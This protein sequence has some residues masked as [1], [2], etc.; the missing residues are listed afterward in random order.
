MKGIITNCIHLSFKIYIY[1]YEC[2]YAYNNAC[3]FMHLCKRSLKRYMDMLV[4]KWKRGKTVEVIIT[5]SDPQ[6]LPDDLTEIALRK[7]RRSA[8]RRRRKR[9]KRPG[10]MINSRA[11]FMATLRAA[12]P[13]QRPTKAD[14]SPSLPPHPQ[15]QPLTRGNP[16]F[17]LLLHFFFFLF[18]AVAVVVILIGIISCCRGFLF[19]SSG[20]P[21]SLVH[22][23]SCIITGAENN[24][25]VCL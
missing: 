2:K 18:A 14:P 3:T 7:N 13:Q 11:P 10:R 24:A 9:R 20:P 12:Q 6:R 15:K 8:Q 21:S 23:S 19:R 17:L 5:P 22:H 1:V 4:Y 16:S 25:C